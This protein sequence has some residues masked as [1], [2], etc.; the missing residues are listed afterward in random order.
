MT[1]F[2]T[3]SIVFVVR[4]VLDLLSFPKRANRQF[5][6]VDLGILAGV[7]RSYSQESTPRAISCRILWTTLAGE[8]INY[9]GGEKR[10][11]TFNEMCQKIWH[12]TLSVR[13]T[14][15]LSASLCRHFLFAA[16][17]VGEVSSIWACIYFSHVDFLTLCKLR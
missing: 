4:P 2:H 16:G 7:T 17:A 3:T 11:I 10:A 12:E 5:A 14:L 15:L 9:E 8:T 6:P 1:F 13:D